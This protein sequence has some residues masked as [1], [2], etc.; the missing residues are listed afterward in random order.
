MDKLDPGQ[1]N[2]SFAL[3]AYA[4]AQV[5]FHLLDELGDDVCWEQF[6]AEAEALSGLETGLIPPVS[7]SPLPDGHRGTRGARITR[8]TGGRWVTVT[9]FI[10]PKP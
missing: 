10:E 3:Q 5:V 1:T 7:F 8:Y 6:Q 2:N 4:S 9:D